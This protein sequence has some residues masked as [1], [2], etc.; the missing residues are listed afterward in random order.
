MRRSGSEG[1]V[2]WFLGGELRTTHNTLG[3]Q[4]VGW[5]ANQLLGLISVDAENSARGTLVSKL[6]FSE[7][8]GRRSLQVTGRSVMWH[9]DAPALRKSDLRKNHDPL[10]QA[11]ARYRDFMKRIVDAKRVIRTPQEKRDLAESMLLRVC[12]NWE[13]FVDEHLVDCVNRD[14]SKLATFLGVRVP[15]HPDLDLCHA[16]IFG[17]GYRDFRSVGALKGFS[18]KVL[19]EPSNPFLQITSATAKRIDE[20]YTIRNYLS[21]YSSKSERALQTVYREEYGLDRFY[22]PGQFLLAYGGKRLWRYFDTFERASADM[23]AWC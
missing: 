13:S 9:S 16:L 1:Q 20:V 14:H 5:S 22:D 8:R 23:R 7:W 17:D 10:D 18:K 6:I 19:P 2:A 12:A 4:E 11:L 3:R 21:H 15:A